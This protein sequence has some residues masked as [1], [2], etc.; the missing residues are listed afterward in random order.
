MR[1]NELRRCFVPS[2]T[3]FSDCLIYFLTI[4]LLLQDLAQTEDGRKNIEIL[5]R[6]NSQLARLNEKAPPFYTN[7]NPNP[8]PN[9][10]SSIVRP[11]C[12]TS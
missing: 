11:H 8:N 2:I 7:P 12:L 10:P 6:L 9:L 5:S 3:F 4:S 1:L